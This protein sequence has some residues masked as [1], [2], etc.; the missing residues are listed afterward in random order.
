MEL[1]VS[2]ELCSNKQTKI[3]VRMHLIVVD[4]N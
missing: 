3:N 1:H 4:M 2:N